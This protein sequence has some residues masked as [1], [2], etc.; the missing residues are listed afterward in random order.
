[1]TKF[2]SLEDMSATELARHSADVS[3]TGQTEFW[4][5]SDDDFK[6][7][8]AYLK[9]KVNA[10]ANCI[11]TQMFFDAEVFVSFVKACRA[12]KLVFSDQSIAN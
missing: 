7:E 4:A 8:I 9:D 10:G 6:L 3:E 2:S 5:C 12:G 11:I 1:M